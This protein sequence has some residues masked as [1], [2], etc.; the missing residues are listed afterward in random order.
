MSCET[1][2]ATGAVEFDHG[3]V[4]LPPEG[5]LLEALGVALEVL[6]PPTTLMANSQSE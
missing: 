5:E 3:H 1:R 2:V 4:P 6:V